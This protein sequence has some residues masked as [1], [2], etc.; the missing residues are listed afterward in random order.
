MFHDENLPSDSEH[1]TNGSVLVNQPRLLITD[2]YCTNMLLYSKRFIIM[3]VEV[4]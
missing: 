3:T 1:N 2:C 4:I